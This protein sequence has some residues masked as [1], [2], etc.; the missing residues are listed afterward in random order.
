MPVVAK[1]KKRM[2]FKGVVCAWVTSYT[3]TSHLHNLEEAHFSMVFQYHVSCVLNWH[4]CHLPPKQVSPE[5]GGSPAG[6]AGS[7][8]ESHSSAFGSLHGWHPPG[9]S[10]VWSSFEC[11]GS[12]HPRTGQ[13]SVPVDRNT[14]W[15]CLHTAEPSAS[16][17]KLQFP[18]PSLWWMCFVIKECSPS[19]VFTSQPGV[20]LLTCWT[21]PCLLSIF[22]FLDIAGFQWHTRLSFWTL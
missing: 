14:H 9:S 1:S 22:F 2:L 7:C 17:A 13:G 19:Q 4:L 8:G 11:W 6:C 16:R 21:N 10:L 3:V 18:H 15:S 20:H 5:K 12:A